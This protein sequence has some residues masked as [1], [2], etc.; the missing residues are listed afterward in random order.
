MCCCVLQ[1]EGV[2]AAMCS[3][4][5]RLLCQQIHTVWDAIHLDKLQIS[6]DK[7]MTDSCLIA[8]GLIEKGSKTSLIL[9]LLYYL[10]LA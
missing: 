5:E 7:G 9:L 6:V 8:L 10:V 1:V 3:M 4:T 2:E